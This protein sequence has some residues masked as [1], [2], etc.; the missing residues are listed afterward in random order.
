MTEHFTA[1]LF[2]Q[3]NIIHGFFGRQGGVSPEPFAALNVSTSVGD[4]AENV[5]AN[6]A[7]IEKSL[8]L[9]PNQLCLLKQ[10]H[11][12]DVIS[13]S[14]PLDR[15][16]RIEADGMVTATKGLGLGILTA[17]CG[18]VL[19]ADTKNQIVGACHAGWKGAVGGIVG[20]VIEEMEKLGADRQYIVAALGPSIHVKNYEVGEAFQADVIKD[21]PQTAPFF[22]IPAGAT[23]PHFNLP[24]CIAAQL[25]SANIADFYIASH[26]TYAAPEKF[27]S[28]RYATHQKTKTGRQ[29]SAIALI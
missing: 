25:E 27:F 8:G 22:E 18:P 4:S 20:H 16:N 21:F 7:L 24:K 10:T 14:S 6:I 3:H 12:V 5:N 29:L 13:V 17:D 2:D 23:A 1:P 11:S 28:H 19:F 9:S 15:E 26:C